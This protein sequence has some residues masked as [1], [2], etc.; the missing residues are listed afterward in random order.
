[1]T[2]L[3]TIAASYLIGSIPF[4]Y[5]FSKLKGADPRHGGSGNVG[6]TNA[7][8]VGGP[9]VGILSLIGDI[10][11]GL[12]AVYI[13]QAAGLPAIGIS[14]TGLAAIIG[15]DFPVFL[16]FNGGK[17]VATTGGVLFAIDPIFTTILILLWVL[18][19]IVIRYFIPTTVLVI[20]F[21]PVMMWMSSW[22][23]EYFIL[24]IGAFIL[25]LYAHRIDLKRYF[26][27]QEKSVGAAWKGFRGVA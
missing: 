8:V 23:A 16:R 2:T 17:G 19:L 9:I 1:M 24:G 5:L 6:A 10:S 14:L 4:S 21:I 26:S 15:H 11:K 13:A 25:A 7:L 22:P 27:G 18:G 12:V 20:G 3:F